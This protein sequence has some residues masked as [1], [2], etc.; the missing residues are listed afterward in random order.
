MTYPK[1]S[2][3]LEVRERTLDGEAV[4]APDA[5]DL[6]VRAAGLRDL[7]FR[8]ALRAHHLRAGALPG[9]C[10]PVAVKNFRAP[11]FWVC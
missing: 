7:P 3:L 5:A 11:L 8:A 1:H 4:L 10:G 9:P 2:E 6:H